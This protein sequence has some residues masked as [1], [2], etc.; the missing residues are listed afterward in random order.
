M[1]EQPTFYTPEQVA[2]VF[3]LDSAN[4]VKENARHWPHIRIARQIRFTQE[5]VEE[6]ARLHLITPEVQAASRNT[7]GRRDRRRS[8]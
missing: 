8:A 2:E 1:T 6:I 3:G 7:F 5:H 4:Y